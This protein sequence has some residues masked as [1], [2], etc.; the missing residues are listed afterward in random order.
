[1]RVCLRIG[2]FP[3][4]IFYASSLFGQGTM[5]AENSVAML[6]VERIYSNTM[7]D[8]QQLY[9]GRQYKE[10]RLNPLVDRG[11]PFFGSDKFTYGSLF[12]NNVLYD[13]ILL[14]YDIL[15]DQ[16]VTE[17]P[18]M[19]FRISLVN[20][21]IRYFQLSHCLFENL[22]QSDLKLPTDFEPGFYQL[23]SNGT[24]PVYA[25]RVKTLSASNHPT[26][27]Q[28]EFLTSD[29]FFIRKGNELFRVRNI[30]S[31]I[32]IF[33]EYE[34]DLK[35]YLKQNRIRFSDD[36]E[37]ALLAAVHFFDTQTE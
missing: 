28:R 22:D 17:L 4:L 11:H 26:K 30:K 16:L 37:K 7:R 34:D 33:D 5:P 18:N 25:K 23:L 35:R 15:Q 36:L 21:H 31:L 19:K 24:V 1:M 14:L 27:L 3:A 20:E 32:A 2:I 8:Q 12:Y 29:I 13:S 10:I 9:N 6:G